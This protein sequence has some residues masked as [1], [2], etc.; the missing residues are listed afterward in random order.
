M[1]LTRLPL[2][3]LA[4]AALAAGCTPS[5][6]PSE[7]T[8]S[9]E[10]AGTSAEGD[11]ASTDVVTVRE[12]GV[13][14]VPEDAQTAFT[15][16]QDAAPVGASMD[17]EVA[18]EDEQTTVRLSVQ[19]FQQDRGYAVHAHTQPCGKTGADAGPHFQHEQDPAATPDK[20][21]TDPA[22]ANARNEFWLD[23]MTDAQGTGE[24]E[25]TVPF[26]FTDRV[27]ASIVVHEAEHTM[28]E[29]GKAGT[30]GARLACLTVTFR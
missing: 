30:A 26:G 15:Y 19:G 28:T 10:P 29:P 8:G 18:E 11:A 17:V 12:S 6:R 5:D 20:P 1:R 14:A 13:L 16:D 25:T 23:L 9:T 2:A 27:P 4:A 22:F 21:S 7:Q 3:V 24:S